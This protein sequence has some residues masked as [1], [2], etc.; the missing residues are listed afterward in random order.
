MTPMYI[1]QTI[2]LCVFIAVTLTT[3]ITSNT[4]TQAD[5]IRQSTPVMLANVQIKKTPVAVSQHTYHKPRVIPV[6]FSTNWINQTDAM[7]MLNQMDDK[8]LTGYLKNM[9][10]KASLFKLI[11]KRVFAKNALTI[12]YELNTPETNQTLQDKTQNMITMGL[13][14]T[15]TKT[16]ADT[17]TVDIAQ[18][19]YAH[20]KVPNKHVHGGKVFV[21]W[22]HRENGDV[23]LFNMMYLNPHTNKNWVSLQPTS[24]WQKG[25]YDVNFYRFSNQLEPIAKHTFRIDHVINDGL[26]ADEWNLNELMPQEE[27]T[28]ETNAA[29]EDYLDI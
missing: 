5:D 22:I 17:S 19:L 13:T 20:L 6:G 10:P 12:L 7:S 29:E 23:R 26:D 16:H 28:P 15:Y 11:D 8:A 18:K 21:T 24:G 9:I 2:L 25:S 4:T 1:K 3:Q 27:T 14:P